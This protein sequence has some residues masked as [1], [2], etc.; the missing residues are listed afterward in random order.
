MKKLTVKGRYLYWDDGEPFFY[1]GDTAWE[2]L[3]VL[4]KEEMEYYFEQRARQGF[5]AVQTVALAEFEG[6]TL[7][8]AYGRC[9]LLN[10]NGLPDP[11][12]PDAEGPYSYWD[13]VDFAVDTAAKY[14]IFIVLL[15]TWGDKFNKMWGKGPEIFTPGNAYIYGKWIGAR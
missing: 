10:E 2:L 13:H 7:K 4:N 1:L 5:N 8:N 15:P 6:A 9:P 14:G 11:E 3:H 12:K